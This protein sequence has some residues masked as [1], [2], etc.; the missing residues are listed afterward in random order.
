VPG[1]AHGVTIQSAAEV[2]QILLEHLNSARTSV[3]E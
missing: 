2:N 3:P 1:A